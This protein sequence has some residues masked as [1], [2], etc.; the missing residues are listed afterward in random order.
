MDGGFQIID[1]LLFAVLALFLVL[2]LG[3]VLGRRGNDENRHADPYRISGRQPPPQDTNVVTMPERK[4]L[5]PEELSSMDPLE[6]GLAQIKAA[7]PSFREK[8]FVKGA[9]AAFEAILEAFAKCDLGMLKTLLDK[10]VYENFAN[11]IEERRKA[12]QELETTIVG[13]EQSEIVKAEMDGDIAHVTV[14]FVTEQVNALKDAAGEIVDGDAANVVKV[15]D[16][17]TFSRNVRSSNP[18]WLL[19]ATSSEE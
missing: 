17:W 9:R 19:V 15:T 2:K 7:D 1:I 16:L 11:A 18:N 14:K 13:I 4:K 3:S 12:K 5:T 10:S 6:A 8:E